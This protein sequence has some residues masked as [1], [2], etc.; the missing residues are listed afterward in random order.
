MNE[1]ELSIKMRLIDEVTKGLNAIEGGL[2][3][4]A[5][6]A[7]ETGRNM[8]QFGKDLT[9]IGSTLAVVGA[10][11]TGPLIM[12]FNGAAKYS[13]DVKRELDNL[14]TVS[15]AFQVTL[16][17]ALVPI[18]KNFNTIL[19]N[20]LKIWN[21]LGPAQQQMIV[22]LVFM[23]GVFIT[24]G[25]V[26]IATTGQLIKF[27]GTVAMTTGIVVKFVA[28]HIP[29]IAIWGLV[30][31][32]VGTLIVLMWKF[33]A[34]SD[35]VLNTV[36]LGV[37]AVYVGFLKLIEGV[38][39]VVNGLLLVVEK[40]WGVF[41]KI[42]G[43][44]NKGAQPAAQG[45]QDLR[46]KLNDFVTFAEEDI[47]RVETK[48]ASVFNGEGDLAAGFD[49]LKLKF[50]GLFGGLNNPVSPDV[51][52]GMK[53]GLNSGAGDSYVY[54]QIQKQQESIA[55]SRAMWQAWNNEKT[56]MAMA[57][58][59]RENEFLSLGLDAQQKAHQSM[60]VAVGKMR[61]AFAAGMSKLI[62]DTI[63]GINNAREFFKQLGLQMLQ[64]LIDWMV[65]KVIN[66][67]LAKVMQAAEV[68]IATATG[69]AVAAAWAPAAA[70]VSLATL[71]SN[72]A[73]AIAGMTAAAATAQVLAIP[74]AEQGAII[75]GSRYGSLVIAG[76]NYK[77][78][79]IVPLESSR[80]STG[81]NVQVD[82]HIYN[83]VNLGD[84]AQDDFAKK[85]ARKVSQILDEDVG[86]G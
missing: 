38:I 69:A 78:E 22:Q 10:A 33:K 79:A 52:A 55:Q 62:M 74:K 11:I 59:Q 12:A 4:F 30:I 65:Q 3:R 64:I 7:Q 34:V 1:R 2:Q 16:A 80:F 48:M 57:A 18:I 47:G 50:S 29:L 14:N 23:C 83:P 53:E 32:A 49:S 20:L 25:G 35:A 26:I 85:V 45:I 28:A 82:V 39:M 66:F 77:Q 15:S 75:S 56:G 72:S 13:S 36:E 40:V 70:M 17:Q 54:D 67:A 41:D 46:M 43:F 68:S 76:E 6:S 37:R 86:R 44:F 31:V 84:E 24:L 9:Q 5:N 81:R 27:A 71:G 63:Q 73:P 42:Y 58:Q 21:D 19:A 60:W 8:K 51:F 61:D